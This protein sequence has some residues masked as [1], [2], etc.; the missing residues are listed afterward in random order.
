MLSV[1]T[2]NDD[3][4]LELTIFMFPS[5]K[6]NSTVFVLLF[7]LCIFCCC[8]FFWTSLHSTLVWYGES[9]VRKWW[10]VNYHQNSGLLWFMCCMGQQLWAIHSAPRQA[11]ML[12]LFTSSSFFWQICIIFP[13]LCCCGC[14]NYTE[15]GV[16]LLSRHERL[17]F[18]LK[19]EGKK[20]SEQ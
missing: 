20:T 16:M 19:V 17:G 3:T 18:L 10:C 15:R 13:S 4:Y 9:I 6:D 7:P 2:N 14:A 1:A 5:W 12:R 8:L 11:T